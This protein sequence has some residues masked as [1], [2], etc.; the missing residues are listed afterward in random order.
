ASTDSGS[1]QD[2]A[3]RNGRKNLHGTQPWPTINKAVVNKGRQADGEKEHPKCDQRPIPFLHVEDSYAEDPAYL[4]HS[5]RWLVAIPYFFSSFAGSL[6]TPGPFFW[7]SRSLNFGR[8]VSITVRSFANSASI[9]CVSS[10]LTFTAPS[11]GRLSPLAAVPATETSLLF[12][13]IGKLSTSCELFAFVW[14]SASSTAVN[15]FSIVP[16][17]SNTSF[18]S[19]SS[20]R[21]LRSASI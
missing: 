16:A 20:L 9:C 8:S 4:K 11:V 14:C 18:D 5:T 12:R 21:R 15:C 1:N 17:V 13:R 3:N 2:D 6:N 19:A 7:D 10:S